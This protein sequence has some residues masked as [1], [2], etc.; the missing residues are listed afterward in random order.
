MLIFCLKR[1]DFCFKYVSL[2][3]H[4]SFDGINCIF[5]AKE[6]ITQF[7]KIMKYFASMFRRLHFTFPEGAVF[8]SCADQKLSTL[9]EMIDNLFT[10]ESPSKDSYQYCCENSFEEHRKACFSGKI[11]LSLQRNW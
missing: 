1:S 2:L 3:G 5:F 10:I 6:L 9:Q 8:I 11:V 7:R 4:R